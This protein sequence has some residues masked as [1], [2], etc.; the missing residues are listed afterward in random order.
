MQENI[1]YMMLYRIA[2]YYYEDHISQNDIAKKEHVSRPHVSRLLAKACDCGIVTI[3]VSLSDELQTS[4]T[5]HVLKEKLGLKDVIIAFVPNE[6]RNIDQKISLNIA[7]VAAKAFPKLIKGCKNIGL[8]WGYTMY[9][10]SLQISYN[11]ECDKLT[12]VPLIGTSGE[13]NPYLQINSI[14]D[15]FAEKHG[16]NSYYTNIPVVREKYMELGKIEQQRYGR[17]KRYWDKLDMAVIGLGP[18]PMEG[19]FL[20]SEISAE[21]KQSIINSHTQGDILSQFFYEDGSTY[22]VNPQYRQACY[23][24]SRLKE[25]KNVVCLAGGSSKVNGIIAAARN[26]FFNTLITDSS[27]AKLI[28]EKI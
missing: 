26:S 5:R 9:Q 13:D 27:T 21:Y 19:K 16:A 25:V 4:E 2:K 18:P 10:T 20:I 17:L 11:N 22:N 24:I 15:R 12:F 23:D 14:V 8:G 3:K 7:T 6:S 28:L 1:D